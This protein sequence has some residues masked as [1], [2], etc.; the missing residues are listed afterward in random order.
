MASIK[1]LLANDKVEGIKNY[2]TY[3]KHGGYA[4]VEKALNTLTPDEVTEKKKKSGLRGRGGAGFPTGMK[5]SF[6]VTTGLTGL[7]TEA[8]KMEG[9][10][11]FCQG[12]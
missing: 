2:E 11:L 5:W 9:I 3:R 6:R 4:S 8:Q 7:S 12:A 10:E 1:L